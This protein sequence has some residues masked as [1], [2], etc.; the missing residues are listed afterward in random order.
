[1]AGGAGGAGGCFTAGKKSLLARCGM[2]VGKKEAVNT[3]TDVE[4]KNCLCK[5][6]NVSN[7]IF[8]NDIFN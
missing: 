1:M 5:I 7:G 6:I 3:G 8:E 4:K 2:V